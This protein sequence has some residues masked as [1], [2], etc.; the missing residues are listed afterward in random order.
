MEFNWVDRV[1]AIQYIELRKVRTPQSTKPGKSRDGATYRSGPQ[2]HTAWK[3]K[4]EKVV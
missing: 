1:A 2:K 3:G 4:G